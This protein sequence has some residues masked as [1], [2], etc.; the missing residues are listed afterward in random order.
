[1]TW[2][3]PLHCEKAETISAIK[4]EA[5]DASLLGETSPAFRLKVAPLAKGETRAD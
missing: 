5:G 1:M 4:S 2:K 3:E